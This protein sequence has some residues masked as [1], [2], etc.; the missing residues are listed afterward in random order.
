MPLVS[1]FVQIP[2]EL[3]SLVGETAE[4][5]KESVADFVAKALA[6][7]VGRPELGTHKRKVGRPKKTVSPART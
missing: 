3:K 6:Q 1:L 2:A 5:R 4:G 7:A